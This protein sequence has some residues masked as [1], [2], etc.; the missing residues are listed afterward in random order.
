[1]LGM[2]NII[3]L[4]AAGIVIFNTDQDAVNADYNSG[5]GGAERCKAK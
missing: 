3:C 1:M 5:L 4:A 2:L